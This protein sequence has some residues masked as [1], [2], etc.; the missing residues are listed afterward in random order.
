MILRLFKL[1]FST[2]IGDVPE[3]KKDALK[4][5]F[6]ALLVNLAKASAEG[7]VRGSRR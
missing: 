7:A 2:L 1:L 3:E 6:G 5:Q 4:E